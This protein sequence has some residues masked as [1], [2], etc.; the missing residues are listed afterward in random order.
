M[1]P[2]QVMVYSPT[3]QILPVCLRDVIVVTEED[4]WLWPNI[5]PE[6]V[7]ILLPHFLQ[8][9]NRL[10]PQLVSMSQ[11]RKAAELRQSRKVIPLGK[12]TPLPVHK[13]QKDQSK[14][15]NNGGGHPALLDSSLLHLTHTFISLGWYRSFSEKLSWELHSQRWMCIRADPPSL[16]MYS[17]VHTGYPRDVLKLKPPI[18][19]PH[20]LWISLIFLQHLQTFWFPPCSES[21]DTARKEIGGNDAEWRGFKICNHL[22]DT[23]DTHVIL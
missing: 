21:V 7:A 12:V 22:Q 17:V 16:S 1:Q 8:N 14:S 20:T 3:E 23:M 11:Q 2:C 13:D 15:K 9:L 10:L 5:Q 6:D 19:L 4:C 18:Y